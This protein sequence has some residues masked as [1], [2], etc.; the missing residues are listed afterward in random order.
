MTHHPA[1]A[2]A[3]PRRMKSTITADTMVI[4]A[5]PGVSLKLEG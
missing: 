2:I 4:N 5:W 3:H 1:V